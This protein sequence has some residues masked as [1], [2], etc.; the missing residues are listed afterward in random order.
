V[1]AKNE[2]TTLVETHLDVVKWVIRSHIHVNEA[3]CGLGFDD[4][5]QEGCIWLWKA[6]LSYDAERA[7]FK[8]YAK[9]VVKN[10]LISYCRKLS[11]HGAKVSVL[12]LD[13]PVHPENPCGAAFAD[14]LEAP[15]AYADLDT[16]AFLSE[17]K[18]GYTGTVRAGIEA[19]EWFIQGYTITEIAGICGVK[20]NLVGA[21]ISR[22]AQ[23]LRQTPYFA[24][25]GGKPAVEKR[26]A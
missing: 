5:F 12:S 14:F 13:A 16:L 9:T 21:R 20:P 23:V 19:L 2:A 7:G 10:G 4:L 1:N 6:A 25:R 24:E 22:A 15:D 17:L 26:A 18:Q 3:V 11:G 8:T